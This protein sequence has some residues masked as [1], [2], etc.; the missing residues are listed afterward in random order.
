MDL[1]CRESR[2]EIP[3]GDKSKCVFRVYENGV[4][5][6]LETFLLDCILKRDAKF[7]GGEN[8]EIFRR[9]EAI[10]Y[11][12]FLLTELLAEL[13]KLDGL[14]THPKRVKLK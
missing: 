11:I 10:G 4:A 6:E 5:Y 7:V 2:L 12:A 14:Y 13:D 1:V 3:D 8:E 9:I